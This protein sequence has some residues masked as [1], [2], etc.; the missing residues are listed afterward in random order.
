M[1]ELQEATTTIKDNMR[2]DLLTFDPRLVSGSELPIVVERR[3]F[4]T[5]AF[6][7]L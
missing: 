5:Y 7:G 3:H 4:G 6:A 1:V 2:K